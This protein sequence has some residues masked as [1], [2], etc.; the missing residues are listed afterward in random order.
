MADQSARRNQLRLLARVSATHSWPTLIIYLVLVVMLVILALVSPT[1]PSVFSV[2]SL[3]A[4]ALPLLFAA[5]AQTMVILV[6]GIDL[7]IG[8]AMSLVMV[9]AASMMQDSAGSIILIILL[10]MAV[11]LGIGA[12]N[13]SLV[14]VARLQPIIVTLATSSI[15]A[16]VALYIMPQPGGHIPSVMNSLA[17]GDLSFI[18]IPVIILLAVLLLVWF[19]LRRSRIG[20]SWYAVGGNEAGA[21][22]SGINVGLA[23]FSAFLIGGFFASLGGLF[24]AFQ[25]LTGDP[26]IGNP[27]TLN[28]IAATVIG[29]TSLAGGRGGA[30]G[31]LGGV[32]V[33]TTVVDILFFFQVSAYYQYVFS[34]AIVIVALAIVTLSEYVRSH[35]LRSSR[36]AGAEV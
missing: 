1:F 14:A 18:P 26:M 16:G 35:R 3:L 25:T 4:S 10:C 17:S 23:K 34:G 22:Y 29:G 7:S 33:L 19:P 20:Q 5:L 31:A 6:R 21:F 28:S 8:P 12:L 36:A 2:T 9:F 32:L 27:F 15:L 24:L 30:L 11:G 13:G